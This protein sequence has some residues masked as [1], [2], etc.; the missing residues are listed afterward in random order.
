MDKKIPPKTIGL[1]ANRSLREG[2]SSLL[3]RFI[4]EYEPYIRYVLKPK[5]YA[6][7]GTLHAMLRYGLFHDNEDPYYYQGLNFIPAGYKGGIVNITNMVVEKP[8]QEGNNKTDTIDMVIYLIDPK[9]QT[10]L[11]PE[12]I[13]LKREC[14]VKGKTFLSTYGGTC[15]WISIQCYNTSQ[16]NENEL[17]RSIGKYFLSYD[18]LQDLQ[19][20]IERETDHLEKSRKWTL[21]KK[22]VDGIKVQTIALIAHDAKKQEILDFACE[23]FDFLLKF[24][25]RIATGTTGQLL[26]GKVPKR[27]SEKWKQLEEEVRAFGIIGLKSTKLIKAKKEMENLKRTLKKIQKKLKKNSLSG[28]DFIN[29]KPSGPEGGDVQIAHEILRGRCDKILFFEDPHVSRE[30]EADIQLLERSS[31][32]P[33]LDIMCLHDKQSATEWA[34]NLEKCKNRNKEIVKPVTIVQ[35]YRL[36]FNVELVLADQDWDTPNKPKSKSEIWS[37]ILSKAKWY[38]IGLVAERADKQ[39]TL[40]DNVRVAVTWG[41]SMFE[42]LD[43]F[44]DVPDRLK[45]LDERFPELSN[46]LA[47]EYF[48]KPKNITSVPMVGVMG[49]TNPQVEA[50]P[51]AARLATF[52]GG[53]DIPIPYYAFIMKKLVFD[54]KECY[55]ELKNKINE[56]ESYWSNL[57]IAIFTC[58][59]LKKSFGTRAKAPMPEGLFEEMKK[60][61]AVGEIG[62]LYFDS[63][64]GPIEFSQY[65]RLGIKHTQLQDIARH[66]GAILIAGAMKTN[67]K[68]VLAALKGNLVSVFVTD[69][70]FARGVLDLYAYSDEKI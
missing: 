56:F 61:M 8:K 44:Q 16:E 19:K 6:V 50:N 63:L 4:R 14:V 27:L 68:P 45:E 34:K 35:A 59:E 52:F 51:N 7:E 32:L 66:G 26:K 53:K 29:E 37:D 13:A 31:R 20:R 10:S 38:I 48:L 55:Q 28:E 65:I 2:P 46:R 42:M 67:I 1:L 5:I 25:N 58:R 70:D 39:R 11:F 30:H 24:K 57:D 64:G 18:L 3:S 54:E 9:D 15:E 33:E 22:A 21:L 43:K 40:G 23:N 47:D 69:L 36:L 60:K 49:S 41:F 12:S 62:G 17:Q